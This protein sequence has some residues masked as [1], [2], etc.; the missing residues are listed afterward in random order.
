MDSAERKL[1]LAMARCLRSHGQTEQYDP[2]L[3]AKFLAAIGAVEQTFFDT[4]WYDPDNDMF[5]ESS[6][7]QGGEPDAA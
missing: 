1:L 2:M 6:P 3:R 7:D 4:G 5:G